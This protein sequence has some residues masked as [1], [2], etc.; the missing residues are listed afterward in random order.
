MSSDTALRTA[1]A[2]PDELLV[3][4]VEA[5]DGL[6]DSHRIATLRSLCLVSKRLVTAAQKC[7][8]SRIQLPNHFTPVYST[9]ADAPHLARLVRSIGVAASDNVLS[10]PSLISLTLSQSFLLDLVNKPPSRASGPTTTRMRHLAC[11]PWVRLYAS[12]IGQS[13]YPC[14]LESLDLHE[15]TNCALTEDLLA[16]CASTLT[17][18]TLPFDESVEEF[19]VTAA[20]TPGLQ[21]LPQL[22]DLLLVAKRLLPALPQHTRHLSLTTSL[23]AAPDLASFLLDPPGLPHLATLRVGG[24]LARDIARLDRWSGLGHKLWERGIEVTTVQ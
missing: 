14:Q 1:A 11:T 5:C 17:R 7:L 2:L 8:Y 6:A 10:H 22:N 3:L 12:R 4:I 24:A 18:L 23:V 9:L 16:N 20:I 19:D 21:P 13:K 15:T